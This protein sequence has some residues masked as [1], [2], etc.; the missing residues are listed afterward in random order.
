MKKNVPW[1]KS[2]HKT[3][4]AKPMPRYLGKEQPLIGGIAMDEGFHFLLIEATTI[5]VLLSIHLFACE[6]LAF[7]NH[8]GMSMPTIKL[9]AKALG[10]KTVYL[11]NHA[12]PTI[13]VAIGK[14]EDLTNFNWQ[15]ATMN[16]LCWCKEWDET[17]W[18]T[19]H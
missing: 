11:L 10:Q 5:K 6:V 18:A 9:T 1:D 3:K 16:F 4:K 7:L 15:E 8:M 2:S 14:E 17:G 13:Q 12:H 19:A